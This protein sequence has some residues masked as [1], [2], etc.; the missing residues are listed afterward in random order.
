MVGWLVW[1]EEPWDPGVRDRKNQWRRNPVKQMAG[2]GKSG[3]IR[4]LTG[5][6]A[7]LCRLNAC[8]VSSD[9][10]I[11][12]GTVRGIKPFQVQAPQPHPIKKAVC[13]QIKPLFASAVWIIIIT[14]ICR[15]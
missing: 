1:G 10:A 14:K 5:I 9:G 6:F 3:R 15:K 8:R 7:H 11:E 13:I 12:V 2:T 4:L